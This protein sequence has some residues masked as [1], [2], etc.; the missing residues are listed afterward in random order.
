MSTKLWGALIVF[1]LWAGPLP[2]QKA[3]VVAR[4]GPYTLTR[5]EF[6]REMEANPQLK[7]LLTAKPQ[8]KRILLERWV[9]VNL[10]ALAGKEAGLAKDPQVQ[11]QIEEQVRMILAQNF[12]LRKVLAGL[13]VTDKEAREYYLKHQKA[14]TQ[15]EQIQARHILIRLPQKA[16][17]KEEAQARA[18]IEKIRKQILAGADFAEMAR[19]YSEDPGTKNRGGEL[20]LF[21][22]GQMIP[23][24]EKEVFKLKVGELSPP[25]R[26]RFGYHLVQVE[27]RVPAHVEPYAK[28]KEQVKKD[29]LEKKKA[30]RL[31][32]LLAQL[33]K[34]Y[35]VELHP[36]NLP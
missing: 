5:A 17:K 12:Y 3:A 23:E 14:Y 31:S 27:A 10:L 36:E 16:S 30:E 28:V 1:F 20:G 13:K 21:T 6:Q 18:K 32:A 11:A 33:R 15:P 2:A 26:T 22:R 7:A 25:I 34:K 24:F 9:E 35:P 29:L 8:M 4:V 19:K